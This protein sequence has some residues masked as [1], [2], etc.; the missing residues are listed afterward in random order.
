MRPNS[1]MAITGTAIIS[2]VATDSRHVSR[3]YPAITS[4]LTVVEQRQFFERVYHCE[5]YTLPEF[6]DAVLPARLKRRMSR[7]TRLL[8][9]TALQ[10]L[11]DADFPQHLRQELALAIGT[12]WGESGNIA[13]LVA[14]IGMADASQGVSPT[15]FHNSVHNVAAGYLGIMLQSKQPAL[16][17]SHSGHCFEAAVE[18][19]LIML[20]AGQAPAALAGAGDVNLE[21]AVLDPPQSRRPTM[22][23]SCFILL[24]TVPAVVARNGTSLA[25]CSLGPG[26]R[27][28]D[29]ATAIA[30]G[31]Q[32]Q[33]AISAE[34]ITGVVLNI[35]NI[36]AIDTL[37]R[38]LLTE[39]FGPALPPVHIPQ[40]ADAA[41]ASFLA[42]LALLARTPDDW[43][44]AGLAS[45]Y[46]DIGA[47]PSP[48]RTCR[49][50][51]LAIDPTNVARSFFVG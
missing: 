46:F 2:P 32:L 13:D 19:A 37:A 14:Q 9:I 47:T 27:L 20:A 33:S 48:D 28:P 15:L 4:P 36:D 11:Q 3:T 24:E 51:I 30:Y 41:G 6:S 50:L 5:R 44:A 22:P 45:E 26:R 7:T 21:M 17:I 42:G 16:T 10:C 35:A 38:P 12:R 40:L 1:V 23:G 49:L 39:L 34:A 18:C 25:R 29:S 8:A 43:V 31:R